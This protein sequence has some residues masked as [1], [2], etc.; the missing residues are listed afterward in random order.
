MGR[1]AARIFSKLTVLP[2]NLASKLRAG[3]AAARMLPVDDKLNTADP[4]GR[5]G[6]TVLRASARGLV[7]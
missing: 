7:L 6:L 5:A 1:C 4:V 3:S 2:G